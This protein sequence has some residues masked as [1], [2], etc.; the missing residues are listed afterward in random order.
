[1]QECIRVGVYGLCDCDKCVQWDKE[2]CE[3]RRCNHI[4]CLNKD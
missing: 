4:N 3:Q 2:Q 1:M